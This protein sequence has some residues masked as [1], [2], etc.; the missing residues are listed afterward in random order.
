MNGINEF[1][2]KKLGELVAFARVGNETVKKGL[3]AFTTILGGED[4]ASVQEI[5]ERHER[6]IFLMA[7][8]F[9]VVSI[10]ET[11][12]DATADKLRTMRDLYVKEQWDNATELSEWSG[13]FE[14]AAI[15]HWSLVEGAGQGGGHPKVEE[16][17]RDA[18]VFHEERLRD[19]EV[20]LKNVGISK[21]TI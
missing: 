8:E 6:T 2:A 19:Y 11:K 9:G 4:L 1:T 3:A 7:E 16:M 10:V 21:T 14:G 20:F 17:A 12:A 15:V 13:F 18:K 5:N